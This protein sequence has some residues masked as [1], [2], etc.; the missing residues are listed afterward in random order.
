MW[1]I[2]EVSVGTLLVFTVWL[3]AIQ[4]KSERAMKKTYKKIFD[5]L[6][7]KRERKQK[8]SDNT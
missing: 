5:D 2:A 4:I 8:A 6:D 1:E 3:L 7:E